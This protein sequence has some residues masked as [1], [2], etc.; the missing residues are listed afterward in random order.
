MVSLNGASREGLT[1]IF[2]GVDRLAT[3][4]DYGR[5]LERL[6]EEPWFDSAEPGAEFEKMLWSMRA[7]LLDCFVYR[8]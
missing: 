6:Y 5:F 4:D 1:R 2:P 7:A 8:T 3:P